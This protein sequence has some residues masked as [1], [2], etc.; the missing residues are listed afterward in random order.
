MDE[1]FEEIFTN[2][3]KECIVSTGQI[4]FQDVLALVELI[5][6]SSNFSEI[7]LRS[8]DVEIEL[9][10]NGG[11]GFDPALTCRTSATTPTATSAAALASRDEAPAVIAPK[12]AARA[13]AMP[14]IAT[15]QK[16]RP[17]AREGVTII[18]APMVG[19]VYH[20]PEPGAAPFVKVGQNVSPGDPICIVE[21]MKLMNSIN[22]E[23]HGVV[24]EILVADGEAVEY[25][26]E[27]FVISTTKG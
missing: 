22:A 3:W 5:K 27:L 26:Q 23:S 17:V 8:G 19:A 1:I 11:A 21:V 14:A 24:T 25:G 6:A 9:R 10:R 12:P 2:Q 7:R 20:A 4:D 16:A 15:D 18:K 13:A